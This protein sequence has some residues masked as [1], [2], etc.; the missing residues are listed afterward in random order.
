VSNVPWWVPALG[1]IGVVIVVAACVWRYLPENPDFTRTDY[2]DDFYAENGWFE[3][4]A[5]PVPSVDLAGPDDRAAIPLDA[6]RPDPHA[7]PV[8][9]SD[10]GGGP[11]AEQEWHTGELTAIRDAAASDGWDWFAERVP[12]PDTTEFTLAG[13]ARWAWLDEQ[14]SHQD[15]DAALFC[16]ELQERFRALTPAQ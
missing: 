10:L 3:D 14:L 9:G 16:L 7:G 15:A 5:S 12:G 2:E 13:A 8:G 6:R 11:L 4:D 1:I